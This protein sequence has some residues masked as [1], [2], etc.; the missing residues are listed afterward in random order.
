[1]TANGKYALAIGFGVFAGVVADILAVGI[2][3]AEALFTMGTGGEGLNTFLFPLGALAVRLLPAHNAHLAFLSA[4][5]VGLWVQGAELPFYGF[6][7]GHAWTRK[8]L[9]LAFIVVA[10]VHLAVWAGA[11]ALGGYPPDRSPHMC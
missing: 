1:M 7:L 2:L 11:A 9:L 6:V 5:S 8:R 4:D 10:F 3:I